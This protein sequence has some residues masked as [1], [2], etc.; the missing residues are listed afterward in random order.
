MRPGLAQ[1]LLPLEPL[2]PSRILGAADVLDHREVA[3]AQNA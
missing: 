2:T 1:D 3:Q